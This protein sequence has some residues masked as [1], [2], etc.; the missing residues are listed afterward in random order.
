M[1]QIYECN[2]CGDTLS[3]DDE[4]AIY[5]AYC[6]GLARNEV[7]LIHEMQKVVDDQATSAVDEVERFLRGE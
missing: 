3:I 1:A 2:E 7:H 4:R 5:G 6:W